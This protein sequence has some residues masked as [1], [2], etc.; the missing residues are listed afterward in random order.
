MMNH[1]YLYR[2]ALQLQYEKD[3]EIKLG[4]RIGIKIFQVQFFR[5]SQCSIPEYFVDIIVNFDQHRKEE[6]K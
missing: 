3:K 5:V 2:H 6:K 1:L 4:D